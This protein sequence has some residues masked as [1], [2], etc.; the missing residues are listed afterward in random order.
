MKTILVPLDFSDAAHRVVDHVAPLAG[1]L[2]VKV[3]LL[4][5]SEPVANYV[6]VGASMDVIAPPPVGLEVEDLSEQEKELEKFAAKLRAEGLTVE[7]LVQL[8]LPVDEILAQSE[9]Q[10]VDMIALGSHGH[11]ALYHLFAGSVVTG[12]LKKASC[13]VLVVPSS[14]KKA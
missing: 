3:V 6:P 13:P 12:V 2:G 14:R 9:L 10:N 5:V 4:H 11:G 8:G 7:T 1:Q